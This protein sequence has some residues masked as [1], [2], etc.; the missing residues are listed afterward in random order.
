MH[1][2]R[3]CRSHC[4]ARTV[5]AGRSSQSWTDL[6]SGYDNWTLPTIKQFYSFIDFSTAITDEVARPT[7]P[8]LE[9]HDP[10]QLDKPGG[11]GR[12][13]CRLAGIGYMDAPGAMCTAQAQQ[14]SDPKSGEPDNYPTGNDPQSDAIRIYNY[15]RFIAMQTTGRH[16]KEPAG[17]G[18]LG[19]VAGQRAIEATTDPYG[20]E[21]C[22]AGR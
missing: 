3:I 14:R 11:V 12:C 2:Q 13:L 15:V 10:R 16:A 4:P 18:A 7:T 9:Q 20:S 8:P 5:P 21:T 17:L 1:S 19:T 6:R 22:T